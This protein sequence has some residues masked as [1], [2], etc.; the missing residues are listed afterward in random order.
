MNFAEKIKKY[1]EEN[2][3]TQKQLSEILNVSVQTVSHWER[4]DRIPHQDYYVLI[5]QRL[6]IP[7]TDVIPDDF[8]QKAEAQI[9]NDSSEEG[10]AR[11]QQSDSAG[12][13]LTVAS[14][15]FLIVRAL[16]F[17]ILGEEALKLPPL[18]VKEEVISYS[19]L[20]PLYFYE[21]IHYIKKG[22]ITPLVCFSIIV[23]TTVRF[24]PVFWDYHVQLIHQQMYSAMNFA[25]T[26]LKWV[27]FPLIG[28]TMI[29]LYLIKKTERR[30]DPI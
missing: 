26:M 5:S 21:V 8:I 28:N 1:R 22:T 13:G 4:G 14:L 24:V 10:T 12:F 18:L 30:V 20:I 16:T 17:L 9:H 15:V 3:M 25:F 23:W 19:V 27:Y 11:A 7:V 29:I 2:G 6:G